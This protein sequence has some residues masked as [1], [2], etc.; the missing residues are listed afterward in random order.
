MGRFPQGDKT[1][2]REMRLVYVAGKYI[3][4][5]DTCT[6]LFSYEVIERNES[7]KWE[8]PKIFFW[9]KSEALQVHRRRT[10]LL[11]KEL[12]FNLSEDP[13]GHI[14]FAGSTWV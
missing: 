3:F 14:N 5:I 10:N 8:V 1:K 7:K 9:E 2:N 13:I 4:L 12:Q 11:D 6:T